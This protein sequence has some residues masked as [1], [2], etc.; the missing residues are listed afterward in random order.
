MAALPR[1]A[2]AEEL[3]VDPALPSLDA[4]VARALANGASAY[5]PRSEAIHGVCARGTD[6]S[7]KR[8][9]R[10]DA[11]KRADGGGRGVR[12]TRA[13]AADDGRRRRRRLAQSRQEE[14]WG[15]GSG[16]GGAPAAAAAAPTATPGA[17]STPNTAMTIP[18]EP[19]DR[20]LLADAL[21]SGG[22]SA[23]PAAA[24]A[25]RSAGAEAGTPTPPA[26]RMDLLMGLDAPETSST[27]ALCLFFC[28]TRRRSSGRSGCPERGGRAAGVR[29]ANASPGGSDDS[30]GRRGGRRCSGQMMGM[31]S[32]SHLHSVGGVGMHGPV[33]RN[34]RV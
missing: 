34:S 5:Q 24:P 3:E 6:S 13:A 18:E 28:R 4:Y 10:F 9:L 21:F 29:R 27:Q 16:H 32:S 23:P 19:D 30:A 11:A 8:S 2:S 12:S 1:D 22:G 15:Q 33:F 14:S 31:G 26:N 20:A 17:V 7:R 25:P